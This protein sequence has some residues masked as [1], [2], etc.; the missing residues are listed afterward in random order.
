MADEVMTQF[1][2]KAC[3]GG[4]W[5]QD[6]GPTHESLGAT[7]SPLTGEYRLI[8]CTNQI[9]QVLDMGHLAQ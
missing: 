3:R 6:P 9:N 1:R 8:L 7:S 2:V 5:L 4:S